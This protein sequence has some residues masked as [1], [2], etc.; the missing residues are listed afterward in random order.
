[1]P[2]A[3][4]TL[5]PQ[6]E[7]VFL[8]DVNLSRLEKAFK[9]IAHSRPRSDSEEITITVED[10]GIQIV[11]YV[12]L[13]HTKTSIQIRT[14]LEEFGLARPE[15]EGI[16]GT[17]ADYLVVN[18]A[19][20]NVLLSHIADKIGSRWGLT[21]VTDHRIDFTVNALNA[22]QP[23]SSADASSKLISSVITMEVPEEILHVTPERYKEIRNSFEEIRLPFQHTMIELSQLYRLDSIVDGRLLQQKIAEITSEFD[24]EVQKVK[25][26]EFGKK[27]KHWT[28]VGIGCL[29]TVAGPAFHEPTIAI[30]TAA[31]S[32]VLQIVRGL[33]SQ[34]HLSSERSEV[35]RLIGRM[36]KKILKESQ[37]RRLF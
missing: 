8:D 2:D 3:F 32:V 12:F 20:S 23:S 13:H 26:S 16:A 35:Q 22:L 11:G 1:M 5:P 37:V 29:A 6:D 15:L 21:T 25:K 31:V 9:E 18:E 14:L 34:T 27:L 4:S 28:P 24:S 33:S 10:G 30:S 36:Q 19:A 17:S 7:D